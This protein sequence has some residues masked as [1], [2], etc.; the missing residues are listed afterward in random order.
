MSLTPKA[1]SKLKS[2]FRISLTSKANANLKSIL[3][4]AQP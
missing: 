3:W 2:S 4:F 1:N